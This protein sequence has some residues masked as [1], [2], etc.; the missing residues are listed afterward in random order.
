MLVSCGCMAQSITFFDHFNYITV[1][2][3]TAYSL[4]FHSVVVLAKKIFLESFLCL[5]ERA[6][7]QFQ[8]TSNYLQR[9]ASIKVLQKWSD[10]P[11]LDHK[12][13][14]AHMTISYLIKYFDALKETL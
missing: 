4:R 14:Q 12:A 2:Y 6:F 13:I 8:V 7:V 11:Y 9:K 1:Y 5:P 3:I 10:Y